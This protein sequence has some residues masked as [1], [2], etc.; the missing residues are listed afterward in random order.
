MLSD[1]EDEERVERAGEPSS[2][3]IGQQLRDGDARLLSATKRS[4]AVSDDENS[5]SDAGPPRPDSSL[6]AKLKELGSDSASEEEE[7]PGGATKD[8]KTL[9]GSDSESGEDEEE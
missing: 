3:L 1:S 7:R 6:A 4:R 2:A 5:D 8:Q 9:F